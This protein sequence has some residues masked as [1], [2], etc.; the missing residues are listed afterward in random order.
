[1]NVVEDF[2]KGMLVG[3]LI[4]ALCILLIALVMLSLVV[5]P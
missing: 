5:F 3:T 4:I 2:A 1:M